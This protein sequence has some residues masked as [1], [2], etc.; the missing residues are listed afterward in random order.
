LKSRITGP[1]RMVNTSFAKS[2]Y[3]PSGK[4]FCSGYMLDGN[5]KYID[6]SEGFN[7]SVAYSAG[8]I[9]S[10]LNDLQTWIRILTSGALL[11]S[12]TQKQMKVFNPIFGD[13]EYGLGLMRYRGNFIG[14][15]GDGLGYHSFMARNV[16]KDITIAIFFNGEYPYPQFVFHELL[17]ILE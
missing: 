13:T 8:A 1:L 5:F 10:D 9:I 17:K 12:S 11:S 4:V 6:A 3:M 14:H 7:M 2:Q 16:E 15:S